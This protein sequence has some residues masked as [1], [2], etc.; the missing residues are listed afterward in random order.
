MLNDNLPAL[1]LFAFV[2][3]VTPGPNNL[4]LLASGA[5]F[6]FRASIPHLLGISSG[7]LILLVSVGLGLAEL[8]SLW[9]WAEVAMKWIGAGYMLYL[10]WRIASASPPNGSAARAARPM[11]YIGAIAFQWVNPKLWLMALSVFS[12]YVPSSGGFALVLG[13]AVLFS[14]I[15]LPTISL[16]A[17]GGAKLRHLLTEQR[18][19][20]VFNL[21]MAAMLLATL[22]P[23][24]R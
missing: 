9:P 24:L 10:A 15:N 11:R 14:L 20:K 22:W 18:R 17:L 5:N 16:W 3:S 23:M 6:G 12:V 4:M 19:V 13:G 21:S 8:F 1:A 2:T 7:V